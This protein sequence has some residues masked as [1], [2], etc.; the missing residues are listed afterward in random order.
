MQA[1]YT[2]A[3]C[4]LNATP[5]ER[6]GACGRNRQSKNVA[7]FWRD[8]SLVA[9]T[10]WHTKILNTLFLGFL[11]LSLLA[12]CIKTADFVILS[13]AKNPRFKGAICTLNLRLNLN[14]T[15]SANCGAWILRCAQYDKERQ[16]QYDKEFV[17]LSLLQKKA[18]NPHFEFMDTSLRSV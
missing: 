17:I 11:R 10:F 5:F 18:K 1:N 3:L 15:Y 16:S 7:V 14:S 6:G 2:N 9:R 12:V 4:H 8:F 13:V